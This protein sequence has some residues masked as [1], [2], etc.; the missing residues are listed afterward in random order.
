MQKNKHI[1]Y[2]FI[3]GIAYFLIF[4]I[5]TAVISN[6]FFT[7]MI[8][9][10]V[11]DYFFLIAS[12]ILIGVFVAVYYYKKSTSKSCKTAATA[13]GIAGFLA[14]G[15]PI[16]NQ[17]LIFVFGATAL[18]TYFEPYRPYL[19]VLSLVVLIVAIYYVAKN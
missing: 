9:I 19:G 8:P 10:T 3:S 12:S 7:R 6:P 11:F 2:G 4:G 13:G 15:C 17:I 18:L 1:L 14:F 16:C 5:V